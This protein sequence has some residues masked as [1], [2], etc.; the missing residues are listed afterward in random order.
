MCDI[1]GRGKHAVD[2]YGNTLLSYAA[3]R[4][5]SRAVRMLLALK[6]DAE[7]N[8]ATFHTY[9][10][11]LAAAACTDAPAEEA[12]AC[13]E[14]LLAARADTAAAYD[15]GSTVLHIAA[16]AGNSAVISLLGERCGGSG[17]AGAGAGF[18]AS[19][20]A[21]GAGAARGGVGWMIN[22]RDEQTMTPLLRAA[23]HCHTEA[24][25]ALLSLRADIE[26]ELTGAVTC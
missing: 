5:R 14:L 8:Y 18:G 13:V 2:G 11:L 1:R 6:C 22:A 4:G 25:Q 19:P 9:P 12:R 15:D 7:V 16:R 10:P 20:A 26:A 23:F 21:P 17:G 24:V 3:E